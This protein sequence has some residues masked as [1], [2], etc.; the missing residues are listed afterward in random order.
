MSTIS[1]QPLVSCTLV[2]PRIGSWVADVVTDSDVAASGSCTLTL[3]GVSWRGTVARGG[4][5]LGRWRGRIV[6]GA[7]GLAPLLGP[8]AFADCTLREVLTE[9][10]RDAGEELSADTA[11]LSAVV[12]RW[13]RVAAPAAHTVADVARAAGLV[14]RVG[15]DGLV[16]LGAETWAPLALGADL[17]VISHDPDAGRWE[18]AGVAALSIVP[19]RV[20]TLDG[21]SVRVGAV[22]HRLADATLRTFV[23]EERET[24]P[25]NRL[26][27]AFETL[28]KRVTRRLDYAVLYPARVVAQDG[29]GGAL[30]VVPDDP[31][32]IV[33]RGIP[34]RTLAGVAITVPAGTR[35]LV[36]F[37]G[38]DPSKPYA[39]LW[40][41]GDV[42]KLVVASGTHRAAREG[43]EVTRS[44]A[45]ATWLTT[46]GTATGA[47]APPSVIGTISQGSD[48]LRLP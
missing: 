33:P 7:G 30:D 15:A 29:D 41:L 3:E 26:L 11:D 5:E 19:G 46:V 44:T 14:W 42:T 12:R 21:A 32:V 39:S 13:A 43:H 40:E 37:E 38:G 22:E 48:A 18:L 28:V 25:S 35:C 1:G 4:V 27:A 10:L 17:D 23:L 31:R 6:G 16:W 34:Y 20:V 47:G 45:F 8:T 24:D 2:V 9:T 36:G